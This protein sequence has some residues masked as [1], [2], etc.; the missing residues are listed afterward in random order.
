[1]HNT[2]FGHLE[3]KI[4]I[5]TVFK[6]YVR[7][8]LFI[9]EIKSL[10]LLRGELR[11]GAAPLHQAAWGVLDVG[12]RL[13][14]LH[15]WH[16][17]GGAKESAE[18]VGGKVRESQRKTEWRAKRKAGEVHQP[19]RHSGNQDKYEAFDMKHANSCLVCN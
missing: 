8:S 18:A 10:G 1:M 16:A 5:F 13:H 9:K 6:T 19:T 7:D 11:K 14:L 2:A 4:I 3:D 15:R 17:G 12:L